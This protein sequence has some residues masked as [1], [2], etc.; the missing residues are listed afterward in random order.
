M[1]CH[2]FCKRRKSC[3][4]TTSPLGS[5]VSHQNQYHATIRLR[6][7]L[8]CETSLKKIDLHIHTVA[9][10]SDRPFSFS[11]DSFKRYVAHAKLDAV[12]VTNHDVFDGEQ[13][14]AIQSA[15]PVTTFPGIEINVD[16]GHVLIVAGPSDVDDFERKT[17]QVTSRIQRIGDSISVDEL[18]AI[19]GNL[20]K[21]LVIPHYDKGPAIVGETLEKLRPYISAGEVDSAKKF[22]RNSKDPAKLT[23]VLFS[24]S[25]MSHDLATFPT[26]Q[27]FL[28]C[29]E[30]TLEALQSCLQDKAK[31]T[32]SE[33]DGNKLWQIFDNGQSLSTG[34]NVILGSRSS[35]KSHTLDK[36]SRIVKNVKYI[37]QFSLVQQE[38]ATS[39]REFASGVERKRS[40][41]GDQYLSGFKRVLDEVTSIDLD[42]DAR[43]VE[44]YL[45]TLLRFADETDRRDAFSNTALFDEVDF[46]VGTFETLHALIGSVR[47]LIENVEYRPIIERHVDLASLKR[48]ALELIETLRAAS[49]DFRKK[50]VVNY[51]VKDIKQNLQIRTS[52]V[53]VKDIDLYAVAMNRKRIERF[54]EIVS[55]L[56]RPAVISE[57]N[58]QGFRIEIRKHAFVGAGEVKQASGR[59]LSFSDAFLNYE[60][61]Y[62]YLQK[63][64]EI[65]DLA[66]A[67]Y[68]RL[69]AKITYRILNKDGYEVS[70]GERSEFRLLQEISDAQNYDLLLVDEPESSFDNLFLKREVNQILKSISEMMPVIVVTHN[71]TVGASVDADYI[72]YTKK[73]VLDGKPIYRIFSGYPMDKRLVS[74]DGAEVNSHETLLNSLE[75]GLAP[76]EGR[77]QSYEAV[78]DR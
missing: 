70:G 48:L 58:L 54:I 68:Y 12:A 37:K 30:L 32:L 43:V 64:K 1:T 61:A 46:P 49:L 53:Q 51:L 6:G 20:K 14:R 5:D 4:S 17:A 62:A 16:K 21:Y 65:E 10:I 73:E 19:F 40:A 22:V 31:V 29:G 45:S 15:L 38:D 52:A 55:L 39:E 24:D 66:T 72:L 9:T 27:T 35:G 13:F 76:Y 63:I 69:F 74:V 42:A 36:I 34:L 47:Q 77:K 56:R 8:R 2:T 3:A 50:K 44:T 26:R 75:A 60:N 7:K 23:P 71:S 59:K 25:R 18:V 11:L 28:D 33:S 67:D 78:K 41:F 57:D